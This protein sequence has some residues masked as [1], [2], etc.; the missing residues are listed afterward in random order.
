MA[1]TPIG[2][3]NHITMSTPDVPASKHFWI[4][5]LGGSWYSESFRLIQVLIGGILVDFFPPLDPSDEEAKPEPGN[6]VQRFRFAITPEQVEPWVSRA[7]AWRVNTRL[8]LAAER[9]RLG[10]VFEAPGGYHVALEATYASADVAREAADRIHDRV[11]KL[12]AIIEPFTADREPL[13]AVGA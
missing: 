7:E 3:M 9:S 5:F 6:V 12:A 13:A 10:L 4:D 11:L 8:L 1:T 2:L